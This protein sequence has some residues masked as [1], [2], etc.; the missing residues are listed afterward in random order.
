[1]K[2][3]VVWSCSGAWSRQHIGEA[4]NKH[5][6][7]SS[8][9]FI[10][11]FS[12]QTE[13]DSS[14][15]EY[16]SD[17]ML[18]RVNEGAQWI[19]GDL[20]LCQ[21]LFCFLGKWRISLCA[22]QALHHFPPFLSWLDVFLFL[23][24]VQSWMLWE[25]SQGG[26]GG[27]GGVLAWSR[28]GCAGAWRTERLQVS[29]AAA[30]CCCFPMFSPQILQPPGPGWYRMMMM[31]MM[32]RKR[33]R[34]RRRALESA[35]HPHDR[36]SKKRGKWGGQGEGTLPAGSSTCL[37]QRC[38][39]GWTLSRAW[40]A[41][42]RFGT[43]APSA[44]PCAFGYMDYC[45]LL[46]FTH[47]S[48]WDGRMMGDRWRMDEGWMETLPPQLVEPVAPHG[49]QEVGVRQHHGAHRRRIHRAAVAALPGPRLAA[50]RPGALQ[51]GGEVDEILAEEERAEDREDQQRGDRQP[52]AEPRHV[53]VTRRWRS[54][55]L[56][57]WRR[58]SG[59][60]G[61]FSSSGP[62]S[63][64]GLRPGGAHGRSRLRGG[65]RRPGEPE[66][67]AGE[68]RV[69]L[70]VWSELQPPASGRLRSAA[71]HLCSEESSWRE[72][73]PWTGFQNKTA[74]SLQSVWQGGGS[75]NKNTLFFKGTSL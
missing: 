13:K 23:F 54:P 3:V 47:H 18:K 35:L 8:F 14:F 41:T 36:Q 49:S 37:R 32:M 4:T 52:D 26:G 65:G 28:D 30:A 43:L 38:P 69:I 61:I 72:H 16:K 56:A 46:S 53:S 70:W 7:E 12:L 67:E 66:R 17:E 19:R 68:E 9:N 34:R 50:P 59:P 25:S 24:S 62:R 22:A 15:A 58:W 31:V 60:W 74:Q 48:C 20:T 21:S 10:I 73:V 33:R 57:H 45:V 2:Q 40:A 42:E 29:A 11:F 44:I 63:G 71:Q 6:G 27:G 51:D 55:A 5:Q 1:M 39:P 75:S 64:S